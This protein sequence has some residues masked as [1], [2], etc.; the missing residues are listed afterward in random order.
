MKKLGLALGGGA[1][2][3]LA[4]IGVLEVLEREGIVV[5]MI[6]GTSAGAAIGALYAQGKPAG[7]IKELALNIGWR[8]LVSL[9]D[10][11]LPRSGFI[12][13]TRIKNLLKSIIGD[14]DFSEL[15]IPLSCVATD[16]R[17]GEEVVISDGP[18]LEGVRASISIPVIFTPVKW[19]ERYLVDGGLVN[20]VPV[21]TV[22]KMGADFVIAVNVIPPMGV[23]LQSSKGSNPPGIFQSMLHSFY[24]ATYSLVRS[25]LAGAD[26]VI[27]PKLPHI[28]YGDFHRIGDS[29]AQGE[30]AAKELIEQIKQKL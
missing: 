17:S 2:R 29:I 20:P 23:R 19:R 7:Q 12:E 1:A 10:L 22:R 16:I 15:K 3:G 26:I 13:G 25:N 4:H 8:R 21:S 28:G 30:I 5:D 6:A 24:I 11:A 14:I 27:E 18:V 9:I